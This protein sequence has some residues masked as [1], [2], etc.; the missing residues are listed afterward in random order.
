MTKT[1]NNVEAKEKKA[2]TDIKAEKR[3][4]SKAEKAVK[5]EKARS[6]KDVVRDPAWEGGLNKK[7][8]KAVNRGN[9]L[10]REQNGPVK[11]KQPKEHRFEALAPGDH[12]ALQAMSHPLDRIS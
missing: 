6:S 12:Q 2:I 1:K 8:A 10:A 11:P 7:E 9:A 4:L 5:D 3:R